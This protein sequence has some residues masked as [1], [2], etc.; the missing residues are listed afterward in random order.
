MPSAYRPLYRLLYT[1]ATPWGVRLLHRQEGDFP[2][3]AGRQRERLGQIGTPPQGGI[4]LHCASVGEVNAA[5]PL[6]EALLAR[7]KS[8]PILLST[9]T[10]SGANQARQRLGDR[11][12][13]R[14]APLDRPAAIKAW[15]DSSQPALALFMETELWPE[16][17]LALKARGIPLALVNARLSRQG[18]TRSRWAR[19]LF[20]DALSAVSLALAQSDEDA[21]RFQALG[22]DAARIEVTGNLKFDLALPADL[23]DRACQLQQRIGQRPCWVAGSTR[24]GEEAMVLQAH[25]R[26]LVRHPDALLLLAPRHPERRGE[27][28]E[29]IQKA[30][31]SACRFDQTLTPQQSVLLVDTLGELMA[32]YANSQ[33]AL[34]GGSLVDIG[35]HNLLEPAALGK[36]VMAGPW[37]HNQS[38]SAQALTEAGA[39]IRVAD[40]A[41]IEQVVE[42]CLDDPAHA[43]GLGRAARQVVDSGRGS[44]ARSLARLEAAGW[45]SAAGR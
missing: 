23:S 37:L 45:L 29:L 12:T 13:H 43:E 9:L 20:R 32:C 39:L 14:L 17:F 6:I 42:R 26:L 33:V 35:G 2:A 3:V 27:I 30:G 41:S 18:L 4:W 36:P 5:L 34:V 7:P 31:L 19:P 44:L 10:L 40:S 24:P 28:M 8:P 11:V 1:L 38:A 15:L 16:T 22:L 25:S 21:Q